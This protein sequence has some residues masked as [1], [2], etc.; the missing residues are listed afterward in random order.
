M[1]LENENTIL[2][3]LLEIISK[4]FIYLEPSHLK[5]AKPNIIEVV[6]SRLLTI[7]TR[8]DHIYQITTWLKLLLVSLNFPLKQVTLYNIK[9]MMLYLLSKESNLD[10]EEQSNMQSIVSYINSR[11][12][13]HS[14]LLDSFSNNI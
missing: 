12:Q 10:P 8:G 1:A 4:L 3:K 14:N 6:V 9:D 2:I 11:K 13:G 7:M 5:E